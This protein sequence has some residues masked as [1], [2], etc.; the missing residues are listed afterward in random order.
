MTIEELADTYCRFI[1]SGVDGNLRMDLHQKI[2]EKVGK[3]NEEKLKRILH[4]LDEIGYNSQM[5]YN[6]YDFYK[7]GKRL[8]R[9]IREEIS[10]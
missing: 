7:L 8:A 2:L 10:E 5:N 6:R 4:N 3:E 9:K 1:H